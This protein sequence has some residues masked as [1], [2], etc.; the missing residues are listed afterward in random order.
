MSLYAQDRTH[1]T[2]Q[3]VG[4]LVVAGWVVAWVLV[5]RA[6]HDVVG[7]LAA[8]GRALERAGL[9]LE[10]GLRATADGV[11]R[12]PVLGDDLRGPFD[13][14]G[15]AALA[16][17]RAGVDVQTGAERVAVLAGVS[18][19]GWPVLLVAGAWA[20]HRWRTARRLAVVRRVLAGPD[21]VDLL[22][23]RAL[24]HAPLSRLAAVGPDV[25]GAWRRGDPEVV[26]A[27]AAVT[28]RDAG[29]APPGRPPGSRG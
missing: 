18:V 20:L 11:G 12:A 19:A 26:A 28:L 29:L 25:A 3:V 2:R 7:R 22:A 9:S 17:A 16:L 10:D 14:A 15:D 27:L 21:G 8:P 5:G 6:V 13:A 4:D 24:A 23:L 1:R